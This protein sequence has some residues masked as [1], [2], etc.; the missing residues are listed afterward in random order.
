MMQ[1]QQYQQYQQYQQQQARRSMPTLVSKVVS[2][3]IRKSMDCALLL[4]LNGNLRLRQPTA[5]QVQQP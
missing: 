1:Q 4:K 2:P 3:E 5:A